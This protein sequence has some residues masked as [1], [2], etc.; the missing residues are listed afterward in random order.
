[1]KGGARE[2]AGR[3]PVGE[4]ARERSVIMSADEWAIVEARA[5]REGVSRAEAL[6]RIVR[7]S[8]RSSRARSRA[9]RS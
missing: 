5:A 9:S 4:D 1:M 6:R 3:P 7:E 8:D 2:G